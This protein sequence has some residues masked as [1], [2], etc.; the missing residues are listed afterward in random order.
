MKINWGTGIF[1]F[2]TLFVSIAIAFMVYAFS[3]DINLVHENYYEKGVDYT[4]QMKM[5]ERSKQYFDQ[6]NFSNDA[7]WVN[8]H[9]SDEIAAS[10]KEGI[11]YFY[12]PSNKKFD[13]ETK[14]NITDNLQKI[15]LKKLALGKYMVKISWETEV[16][17]FY[18]EKEFFIIPSR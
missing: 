13:F 2:F 3:Q 9:F 11:V 5:N 14:L 12:R 15:D 16:E 17:K 1:I 6:I 8:I 4:N 18:I 10:A 7:Q